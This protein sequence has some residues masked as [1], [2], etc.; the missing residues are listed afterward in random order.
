LK[1]FSD[2]LKFIK[3]RQNSYSAQNIGQN[4]AININLKISNQITTK[5][6]LNIP[7]E[8]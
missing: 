3:F 1:I 6:E 8:N 2:D 5:K 7:Q 4:A